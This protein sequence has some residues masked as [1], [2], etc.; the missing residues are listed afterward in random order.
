[1]LSEEASH[2]LGSC[3]ISVH[4]L[5]Y[6]TNISRTFFPRYIFERIEEVTVID[7]SFAYFN[8]TGYV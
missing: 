7:P 3:P 6:S 4:G 1:M 5:G 2:L 8:T